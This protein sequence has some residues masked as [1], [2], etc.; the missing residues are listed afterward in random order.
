MSAQEKPKSASL[1]RH[2]QAYPPPKYYRLVDAMSKC[3]NISRSEVVNQAVKEYFDRMPE[4]DR[5]RILQ[6]GSNHY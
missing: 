6:Q 5:Q 3:E 4:Q 1:Q 2:V